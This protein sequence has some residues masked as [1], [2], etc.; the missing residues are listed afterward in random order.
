MSS[1]EVEQLFA[2]AR[3]FLETG[4]PES[5]EI[6]LRQ[7]IQAG[8]IH[9]DEARRLLAASLRVVRYDVP[10]TLATASTRGGAEGIP[11]PEGPGVATGDRIW[12]RPHL[13][14]P[15]A[16]FQPNTAYQVTVYAD[17]SD[18]DPAEQADLIDLDVPGQ[19]VFDLQ[20][21]LLATAHFE[22]TGPAT[23]PFRIVRDQVRSA[24]AVFSL[25][26]KDAAALAQLPAAPG[27]ALSA[28]FS[29]EGRQAGSVVRA[30]R[31]AGVQPS[32]QPAG[33]PDAV[34]VEAGAAPAD[35][36]V[37]IT[38][39]P[40]NDG[41]HFWCTVRRPGQQPV[42]EAWNLPDSTYA[43]VKQFMSEFT[44]AG[45]TKIL[46]VASLRGAG[47]KLYDATPQSFKDALWD[48]A[49]KGAL[50]TVAI[51][52][53][54]PYIPWELMIPH[55]DTGAPTVLPPLGVMCA[56]G[57]WTGRDLAPGLQHVPIRDSYV[58][59]PNYTGA[60]ALPH[61]Q[62]EAQFVTRQ[63]AGQAISPATAE[64]ID[65]T[66]A[67]GGR[68]MIHIACHG[69]SN[70]ASGQQMIY[71]ESNQT[72]SA[73]Q[74]GGLDGVDTGF[75]LTKPL[76]FL[77]A[78]EVGRLAPALAGV[79]GFAQSF[80]DLGA[81]AVIA[82]LWSVKDDLAHEIAM[83]FYQTIQDSPGTPFAQILQDI[84]RKAYDLSV[85][86]DTY[87][88]YCFYGDPLAARA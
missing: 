27:P 49:D 81:R 58:I 48:L 83:T 77:N 19:S 33:R 74:I 56:V 50:K 61:A 11:G 87:A 31:I 29:F 42:T 1:D 85:G 54:E 68:S 51:V 43:I 46:R 52:S 38:A 23:Q 79:G 86:E 76:V 39:T 2:A 21:T 18:A 67:G 10:F 80:I 17:Q 75:H 73:T 63:F 88:A 30:V 40:E 28:L 8:G 22:I 26:A 4:D 59:A 78:C 25:R 34:R 32:A 12:R 24:D 70:D 55:R 37:V 15:V 64:Q 69:A 20:A 60:R 36:T 66:L 82:P 14:V 45:A 57:R 13:G 53:A 7:Y 44:A 72:L 5:A 16:E 9:Q 62:E 6:A 35:M 84:R 65:G 3:L 41:R 47:K 71:L